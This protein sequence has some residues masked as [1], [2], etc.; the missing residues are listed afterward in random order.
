MDMIKKSTDSCMEMMLAVMKICVLVSYMTI[1]G[2]LISANV[3]KEDPSVYSLYTKG[4]APP[5]SISCDIKEKK[6]FDTHYYNVHHITE[7]NLV[8]Y[9]PGKQDS[10]KSSVIIIPGGAYLLVSYVWEGE[11]VAKAFNSIGVTAFVLKYRLP[12][13]SQCINKQNQSIVALQDV[14][15]SIKMVRE[16]SAEWNIDPNRIGLV[17][18]SAG[19]HLAS[20]AAAK[21][22]VSYIENSH[23]TNLRPDF[24]I[25]IYP[26]I[27]MQNEL[28]HKGS[29]THLLGINPSQELMDSFSIEK[30]IV[31]NTP[32]TFIVHGTNDHIVHVSNS[33]KLYE[34]LLS[35]GIPVEMHLLQD[36]DH[37]ITYERYDILMLN[38]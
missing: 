25:L 12:F 5:N 3:R 17:G 19:G 37:G 36:A 21:F 15:E 18:F 27:S 13:D 20:T 9:S 34:A 32:R 26:V 22:Q 31:P 28:T 10:K 11:R 8:M 2:N 1:L 23:N 38:I 14:Q 16:K 30:Q 6:T 35:K 24:Q 4:K 7:P 29:Q 33:L